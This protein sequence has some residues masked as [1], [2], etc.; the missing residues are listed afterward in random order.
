MEI[1]IRATVTES[2]EGGWWPSHLR[3]PL[4][5]SRALGRHHQPCGGSRRN[6]IS[7][8][9]TILAESGPI[10]YLERQRLSSLRAIGRS[11]AGIGAQRVSR[12][13]IESRNLVMARSAAPMRI[14]PAR[15]YSMSI[16]TY[17]VSV[18]IEA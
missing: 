2:H 6:A 12:Y 9:E 18:T 8:N 15:G 16:M 10:G 4:R 3:L 11:Q 13:R 5:P 14:R 1:R 7:G 17:I